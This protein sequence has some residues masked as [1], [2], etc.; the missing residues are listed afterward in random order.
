VDA[1]LAA[2]LVGPKRVLDSTPLC[3]AV[4]TMDS[5]TLIYSAIRALLKVVG[6]ELNAELRTVL[7]S[8]DD[9]ARSAKP[10]VDCE[11]AARPASS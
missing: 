3:D 7:R 4:A 10:Q 9:Y 8:G 1:A 6:A 11:N 5:I 2:G